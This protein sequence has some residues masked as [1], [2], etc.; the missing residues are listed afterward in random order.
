VFFH[1]TTFVLTTCPHGMSSPTAFHSAKPNAFLPY[2]IPMAGRPQAS[3][4]TDLISSCKASINF[5]L[6]GKLSGAAPNG[7]DCFLLSFTLIVY[8]T[9]LTLR[10]SS[11]SITNHP[12]T[13]SFVFL[14]RYL[15][16]DYYFL[17]I[18]VEV[19][20]TLQLSPRNSVQW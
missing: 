19:K 17:G 8:N 1:F 18:V 6:S 9:H 2:S 16:N 5:F 10:K 4:F 20:K 7:S 3:P 14:N 15:L 11:Y 12:F 13:H